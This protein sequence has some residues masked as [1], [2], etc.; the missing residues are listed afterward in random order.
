MELPRAEPDGAQ[1]PNRTTETTIFIDSVTK[2]SK[3][4]ERG[5]PELIEDVKAGKVPRL[6]CGGD[7]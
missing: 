3:V 2:A 6:R 7:H 5:M 4:R 1:E